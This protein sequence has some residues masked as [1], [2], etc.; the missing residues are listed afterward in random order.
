MR[1][2]PVLM[3]TLLRSPARGCDTRS[4]TGKRLRF[5]YERCPFGP[6][7]IVC[8]RFHK[9]VIAHANRLRADA[10]RKAAERARDA[11]E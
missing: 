1:S 7:A 8:H 3:R 2:E 11:R 10:E 6:R 9:Q 4:V 5:E